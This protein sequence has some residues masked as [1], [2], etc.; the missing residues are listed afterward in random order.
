M[1]ISKKEARRRFDAWIDLLTEWRDELEEPKGVIASGEEVPIYP[2]GVSDT[3]SVSDMDGI[4]I[5]QIKG[6]LSLVAA[7]IDA[8]SAAL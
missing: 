8:L 2:N 1:A 6:E 7:E 4:P 3:I 5:D